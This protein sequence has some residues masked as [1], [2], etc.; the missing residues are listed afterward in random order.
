MRE[1]ETMADFV[2]PKS[3]FPPP[4]TDYDDVEAAIEA[5]ENRFPG[6]KMQIA[7]EVEQLSQDDD[8]WPDEPMTAEEIAEIEEIYEACRTGRMAVHSWD[9]IKAELFPEENEQNE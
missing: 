6:I 9:D 1:N 4:S 8:D 3:N 5:A 7:A 2:P